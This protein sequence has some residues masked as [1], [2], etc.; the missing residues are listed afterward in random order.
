MLFGVF[1]PALEF[2]THLETSPMPVKGC[3]FW[4]MLGTYVHWATRVLQRATSTVTRSNLLYW[5]SPKTRGTL[6]VTPKIMWD[7]SHIFLL[8][9]CFFFWFGC[10]VRFYIHINIPL[11]RV[12]SVLYFTVRSVYF[13]VMSSI[14]LSRAWSWDRIT[15]GSFSKILFSAFASSTNRVNTASKAIVRKTDE[16]SYSDTRK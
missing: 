9:I 4:P 16:Q 13:A 1:R 14:F 7:L 5:S 8:F 3:K 6:V 10:I 11:V 12:N 2:F 15:S